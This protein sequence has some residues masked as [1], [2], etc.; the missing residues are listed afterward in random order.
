MSRTENV[1]VELQ[2]LREELARERRLADLAELARPVAH[3]CNNFLNVL[4]LQLAVLEMELPARH[5][6]DLKEL[7]RQG[8]AMTALLRQYQRYHRGP[9]EPAS[10]DLNTALEEALEAVRRR[11]PAPGEQLP[12]VLTPGQPPGPAGIAVELQLTPGLPPVPASLSELRRL[13]RFLIQ[14]ALA[15]AAPPTGLVQVRTEAAADRIVS[16]FEDNGP[17]IPPERRSQPFDANV[18]AREGSN[19]LELAACLGIARRL[20]GSLR[21]ED[22][23]GGVRMVLE[24]PTVSADGA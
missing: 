4:L 17:P 6:K 23:S 24:L 20:G 22:W 18:A 19:A 11:Q 10:A 16:H 2:A 7:R 1:Q 21:A 12:V 14:N 9:A 5:Q 3:E 15:V 8:T 13:C